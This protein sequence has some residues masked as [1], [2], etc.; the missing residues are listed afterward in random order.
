M[1][2]TTEPEILAHQNGGVATL[3]LNRPHALNALSHNM[4]REISRLMT[5][6]ATDDNVAV[7]VLRGAGLKAFCAGGDV[8]AIRETYLA[9]G[10]QTQTHMAFFEDEYRLDYQIHQYKKPIIALLDGIVMGGGMGLAQAWAMISVKPA[11][12][13]R[14]P[15]RGRLD[16]GLRADLVIVNA[17]T[18]AVEATICGGRLVSATGEA[19]VRF[20]HYAQPMRMAGVMCA[21][22]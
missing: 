18:R 19:A 15:D 22:K 1:S 5:V 4:V 7:V 13:L 6:W 3:T 11:E 16:V 9:S 12:I 20:A 21:T 14:L 17:Q 2:T 8:R 10:G